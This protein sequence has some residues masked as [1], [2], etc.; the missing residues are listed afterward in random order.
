M[1]NI[2]IPQNKETVIIEKYIEGNQETIDQFK[3]TAEDIKHWENIEI[4]TDGSL[5]HFQYQ[6][7]FMGIGIWFTNGTEE[8]SVQAQIRNNPSSTRAELAAILLAIAITPPKKKVKIYT[9]SANVITA[10]SKN[11]RKEEQKGSNIIIKSLIEQVTKEKNLEIEVIKVKAHS[12]IPGNEKADKLAKIEEP[13][14][15]AGKNTIEINIATYKTKRWHF[16]W[17]ELEPD[18]D[19]ATFTKIYNETK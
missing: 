2:Q 12:G 8:C 7:A 18:V 3:K 6:K 9:D 17:Q 10:M 4:Y 16:K 13:N 11:S 1:L 19:I 15:F 14:N 5:E